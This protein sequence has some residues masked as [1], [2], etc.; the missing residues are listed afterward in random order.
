MKTTRLWEF[1]FLKINFDV[2]HFGP[3]SK[4][5]LIAYKEY[6]FMRKKVG[7]K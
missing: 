7:E 2:E 5:F 1:G 4:Y 6:K 3:Q